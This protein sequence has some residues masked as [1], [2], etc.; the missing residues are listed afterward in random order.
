[1]ECFIPKVGA[2]QPIFDIILGK[3]GERGITVEG[4]VL[5]FEQIKKLDISSLIAADSMQF[6]DIDTSHPG[7]IRIMAKEEFYISSDEQAKIVLSKHK[8]FR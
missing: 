1:M 7:K 8:K 4:K 3:T 5:P 6:V 2:R